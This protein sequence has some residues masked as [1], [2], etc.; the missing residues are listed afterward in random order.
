MY[1]FGEV[2]IWMGGCEGCLLWCLEAA[3]SLSGKS[4]FITRPL[5]QN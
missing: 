2:F 5:I 3:F 4:N 1:G